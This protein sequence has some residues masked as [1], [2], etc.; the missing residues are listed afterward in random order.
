MFLKIAPNIM[1]QSLW[2]DEAFSVILSGL[3]FSQLLEVTIND[4]N[5]PLY[6]V[7]LSGWINLFGSGEIGVRSL[8]TLFLVLT[9]IGVFLVTSRLYSKRISGFAAI[10]ALCNP[11]LFYYAFEA[12]MYTLLAFL[13]CLSFYFLISNSWVLF[14]LVTVLGLYTHNFMVVALISELFAFLI[15]CKNAK[16]HVKPLLLSLFAIFVGY[17]PWLVAVVGQVGNIYSN[18]WIESPS[19]KHVFTFFGE[20]LLDGAVTSFNSRFAIGL[21][22]YLAVLVVFYRFFI[23]K[24]EEARVSVAIVL[25]IVAPVFLTLLVSWVAV[26]LFVLRYLIFV[27]V[28]ISIFMAVLIGKMVPARLSLLFFACTL[29]SFLYLNAQIFK[30][31]HKLDIRNH[32]ERIAAVSSGE[33]L[34]CGTILDFYQV[35]YYANRIFDSVPSIYVLSSGVVTYAGEALL[36]SKEVLDNLPQGEYFYIERENVFVCTADVCKDLQL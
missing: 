31:P 22:F 1:T 8:S 3:P 17:I 5:P 28:P 15:L 33:P 21:I 30:N 24:I 16:E 11:F 35:K 4:F 2:R 32:I 10:L 27:V 13:V 25:F 34:V 29:S 23:L 26:P 20:I 7:V 19:W 12:R 14:S 36:E 9:G 6:Y 18:F